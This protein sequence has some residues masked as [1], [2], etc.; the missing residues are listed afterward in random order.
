[1]DFDAGTNCTSE[2][3]SLC[4]RSDQPSCPPA[5][6]HVCSLALCCLLLLPVC[7]SDLQPTSGP[8]ERHRLWHCGAAV[9]ALHHLLV[10]Q[11]LAIGRLLQ[12][13]HHRP[14]AS[15]DTRRCLYCP[16]QKHQ[17]SHSRLADTRAPTLLA[18]LAR[19]IL[20]GYYSVFKV[21]ACGEPRLS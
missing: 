10:G 12:H 5:A 19:P 21:S 8:L 18:A 3:P 17:S 14:G 9:P 13:Q 7:C 20:R 6:A 4:E 11:Q 2:A 16:Q 15:P 1:V